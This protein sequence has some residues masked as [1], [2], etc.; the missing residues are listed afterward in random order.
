MELQ[1]GDIFPTQSRNGPSLLQ[2][3]F[4]ISDQFIFEC[5]SHKENIAVLTISVYD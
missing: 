3:M 4:Y 5:T 2:N 1:Q